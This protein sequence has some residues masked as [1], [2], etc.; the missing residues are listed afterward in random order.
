MH[1]LTYPPILVFTLILL[2]N[3]NV[4][5]SF[6]ITR[7]LP[8]RH[9]NTLVKR[10]AQK[11]TKGS[12]IYPPSSNFRPFTLADSFP[13]NTVPPMVDEMLKSTFLQGTT[14]NYNNNQEL[15]STVEN[16]SETQSD[17]K[18]RKRRNLFRMTTKILSYAAK[19]EEEK[20]Q[21]QTDRM[22]RISKFPILVATFLL[23]LGLVQ[24][25]QILFVSF[26]SG[27]LT[28]LHVL[29]STSKSDQNKRLPVLSALPPQ[30][31]VPTLISNPLGTMISD[32]RAYSNWL[33]IGMVLG[34]IAPILFIGYHY[35]FTKQL[36]LVYLISR[37]VFVLSC[38]ISTEALAKRSFSPLPIRILIPL[39]Y[40]S[41]RMNS[42]YDWSLQSFG[43]CKVL[44]IL[45]FVYFGANL[46]GF[47]IPIAT[48]NYMRS[49]FFGVEAAEVVLREDA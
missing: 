42:L 38:Q 45:N 13:N 12:E 25:T 2:R 43:W 30:G 20:V 17:I 7:L 31:H 1:S 47:L 22:D 15:D 3:I 10:N 24:P 23:A 4:S 48:M 19:A 9:P 11:Y 29:S 40:N 34:Y 26:I 36:Q 35:L 49:Y 6:Q 21:K 28:F 33:L 27:Y 41:Y 5:I 8:R 18:T 37:T 39:A 16:T 44:G 32:S 46:F 14:S